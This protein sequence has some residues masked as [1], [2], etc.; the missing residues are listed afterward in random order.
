MISAGD[1][2]ETLPEDARAMMA[3]IETDRFALTIETVPFH[4]ARRRARRTMTLQAT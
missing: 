2:D 3:A 1:A 4:G